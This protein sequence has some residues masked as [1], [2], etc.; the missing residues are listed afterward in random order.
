MKNLY[1]YVIE[2]DKIDGHIHLFDHEGIID[3]SLIDTSK[4]CVCFADISFKYIDKYKGDNMIS[5]YDEFINKCYDPTLHAL[6]ATGENAEDII[7]VY[8]RY[9]DKIKGFGELKCYSEYIHGKLP[10]GNLD[11]I[12]PVLDYNKDLGLPVYIHYNLENKDRT[13]EF[14]KLLEEYSF[15]IV[16]CHCGMYDGCDYDYIDDVVKNLIKHHDNLYIDISYSAVDFY[17]SN[18]ERLFEF[19]NKR[20]IIG[21]DINSVIDR[22]MDSPESHCK[23]LYNKFYKLHRLGNFNIAIKNIFALN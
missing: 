10:Y 11:W 5:L 19:D 12:K 15:P 8:E 23:E 14:N 17:L 3:N 18:P 2:K 16:L 1:N 9:P 22:Q 21:T 6:L 20:V 7:A 13:E 4:K